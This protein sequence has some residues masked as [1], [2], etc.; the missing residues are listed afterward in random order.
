[1]IFLLIRPKVFQ[2][3]KLILFFG[4]SRSTDLSVVLLM[5]F[6]F[7]LFKMF[8]LILCWENYLESSHC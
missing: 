1:V 2:M 4:L 5:I 8:L 3:L 6:I 7:V